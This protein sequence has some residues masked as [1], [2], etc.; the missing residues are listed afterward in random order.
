MSLS[1]GSSGLAG[2]TTT[3]TSTRPARS[4]AQ[5]RAFWDHSHRR[6]RHTEDWERKR[7]ERYRRLYQLKMRKQP[8]KH[9]SVMFNQHVPW[10]TPGWGWGRFRSGFSESESGSGAG[11]NPHKVFWESNP[12]KS[13]WE[14]ESA[15]A[16]ERMDQFRREID[17]DPHA[18]LFGSRL[19]RPGA[20]GTYDNWFT[21]LCRTFLGLGS[22][23]ESKPVDTTASSRTSPP[24][25]PPRTG[26][27]RMSD[28]E[29]PSGVTAYTESARVD[30]KNDLE[31]DPISGRMV[32]KSKQ[33]SDVIDGNEQVEDTARGKSQHKG[34]R[35]DL[36]K[37][38]FLSSVESSP[39][40]S[41]PQESL[42]NSDAGHGAL[43][44][45]HQKPRNSK[46]TQEHKSRE[47]LD[48]TAREQR[49]DATTQSISPDAGP[50]RDNLAS[51][52]PDAEDTG[53]DTQEPQRQTESNGFL[54]SA[55]NSEALGG[56]PHS[57]TNINQA[58]KSFVIE[59]SPDHLE[60]ML[61]EKQED[62]DILTASD[63]R[64]SYEGKHFEEDLETRKQAR[65]HME[66]T[67]DS[68]VDPASEIDP[69]SLRQKYQQ[70]EET[71]VPRESSSGA[72]SDDLRR[73]EASTEQTLGEQ[74]ARNTTPDTYLVLAYDPSTRQIK[75]A[76]TSSSLHSTDGALHPTKVLRRLHHPAKFLPYFAQMH[77]GGYEIV[78]GGG[79]ILVF[80][81]TREAGEYGS[82]EFQDD[83]Q[84]P[85]PYVRHDEDLYEPAPPTESSSTIPPALDTAPDDAP[86][87]S[88][89][90]T[91]ESREPP[92]TRSR[93]GS[94]LRRMFISGAAT[95][96]TCYAIGVVV[97]FLRT[98]GEDGRGFDAFTEFE[99]E[100]RQ[101]ERNS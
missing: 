30:E 23:A 61:R 63:I 2:R 3:T 44:G 81:K 75:E 36:G 11:R 46:Q 25:P 88:D 24:P 93:F 10:W 22:T 92:K 58:P 7:T 60:P 45:G 66:D 57:T 84:R 35:S 47:P 27:A 26:D 8:P 17:A 94:A 49:P 78:S 38:G 59:D 91:P 55:R 18:A 62:L 29:G 15:R 1:P 42:E 74:T 54:D 43:Y 50:S 32:P 95:A 12:H 51:S 96:A 28:S 71:L 33:S 19:V 73:P 5:V 77:H 82:A 4:T 69:Q 41:E 34:P 20:P 40:R 64:A 89:K 53:K 80:R 87:A 31:F 100:R 14:T 97:E 83:L 16:K 13:F 99:S 37:A 90:D 98:G 67:F 101:R 70:T 85:N 68:Y 9:P 65:K 79:D 52:S 56:A 76:E 72:S 86:S 6:Y 21:D 48:T 39:R